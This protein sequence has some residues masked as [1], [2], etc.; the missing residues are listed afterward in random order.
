MKRTQ[1]KAGEFTLLWE[2]IE[3]LFLAAGFIRDRTL[4]KGLYHSALGQPLST[5]EISLKPFPFW[6]G[7]KRERCK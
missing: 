2:Q 6:V 4:L 7:W 5:Y 1:N 3:K